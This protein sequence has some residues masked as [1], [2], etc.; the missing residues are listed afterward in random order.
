M[1]SHLNAFNPNSSLSF[2]RNDGVYVSKYELSNR[3]TAYCR[4][5]AEID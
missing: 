2:L 3:L 5:N 1:L 4:Q